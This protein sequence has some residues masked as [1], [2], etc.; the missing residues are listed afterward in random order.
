MNFELRTWHGELGHFATDICELSLGG[1]IVSAEH[2]GGP[3]CCCGRKE[4]RSS[5]VVSYPCCRGPRCQLAVWALR[6]PGEVGSKSSHYPCKH[7]GAC[8]VSYHT[9]FVLFDPDSS[10]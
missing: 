5:A 2:A 7:T 6:F 3:G 8:K 4:R 10:T 1:E 9:E